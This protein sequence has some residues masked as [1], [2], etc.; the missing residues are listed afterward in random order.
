M[1][2]TITNE[3]SVMIL[4][5]RRRLVGMRVMISINYVNG[6]PFWRSHCLQPY[7][8]LHFITPLHSNA[9]HSRVYIYDISWYKHA[10]H[11]FSL[12]MLLLGMV[13]RWRFFIAVGG[14][15]FKMDATM[16]LAF[17]SSMRRRR[18][19]HQS[20]ICRHHEAA[21]NRL[22]QHHFNNSLL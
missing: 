11:V 4:F 7:I 6:W 8:K 3:T 1:I 2:Q 21:H 19:H 17:G 10:T 18:T 16:K 5:F 12:L 9:S 13:S 22:M 20:Y 14:A 15:S